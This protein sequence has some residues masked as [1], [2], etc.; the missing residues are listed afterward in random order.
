MMSIEIYLNLAGLVAV[1]S[2]LWNVQQKQFKNLHKD[3]TE[4]RK[5]IADLRDRMARLEGFMEGITVKPS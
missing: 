4:L 1:A 2:F 3:N 5:D